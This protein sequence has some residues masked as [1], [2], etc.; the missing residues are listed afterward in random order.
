MTRH[1]STVNIWNMTT[2]FNFNHNTNSCDK[3]IR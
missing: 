2:D 3:I 1:M